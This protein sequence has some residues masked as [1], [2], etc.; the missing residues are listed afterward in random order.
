MFVRE[1]IFVPLSLG[2]L[3]ILMWGLFMAVTT[4][5]TICKISIFSAG[6]GASGLSEGRRSPPDAP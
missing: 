3:S 5:M 4:A 6:E 2:V 1:H